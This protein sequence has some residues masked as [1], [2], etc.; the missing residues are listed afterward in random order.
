MQNDLLGCKQSKNLDSKIHDTIDEAADIV[1]LSFAKD[2]TCKW[3]Q[4]W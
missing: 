1:A 2:S 4:F 3:K